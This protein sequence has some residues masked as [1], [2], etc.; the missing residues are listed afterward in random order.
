[1]TAL[2]APEFTNEEAA[3][4]HIEASRWP[5]GVS[6]PHCGSTNVHRMEGKTQAGYFLCNDCRD[7][8]TCRT[9][10][11]MERS[12]IPLHKW[13]LAIHLMN[14]SKKGMSAHQLHRML[15]IT[16]KSAWF[17]AHRI[18]EAMTDKKPS[19]MGGV[20]HQVQADETYYGNTSK[21]S[22]TYR[23]G[24]RHK[25]GVVALTN[26]A[27]GETRA[28]AVKPATAATV[29]EILV[30]NVHRGTTLVT[31]ESALYTVTGGEYSRHE[32]VIHTGREYVNKDGYTTNNVENFFGIFKKG[33]VGTYHFCG[34]QHLQR[35]LNEFLVPLY[36]PFWPRLLRR[37]TCGARSQ[38]HRRQAPNVSTA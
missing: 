19:G 37:G 28:F 38:R 15:G 36:F 14:A 25:S 7:K 31:D 24:T 3:I 12:H 18:R 8:F 30:T 35:Y 16:Y 20:G 6:C 22:K 13:L 9:G 17:L 5:D 2:N 33:M 11:V 34:E 32:T 27:T 29:R 10:T 26:P 1:M 4:A 23:K 21:R